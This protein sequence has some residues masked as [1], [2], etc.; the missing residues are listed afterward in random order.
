MT[1]LASNPVSSTLALKG[2][3]KPAQGNALGDGG[4]PENH[5]L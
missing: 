5:A 4:D 1:N 2:P 3:N